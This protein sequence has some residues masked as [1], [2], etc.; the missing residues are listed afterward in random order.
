MD[1][2]GGRGGR[3]AARGGA[4]APACGGCF[5]AHAGTGVTGTGGTPGVSSRE[6]ILPEALR[7]TI[8]RAVGRLPPEPTRLV[9]VSGQV[10][11]EPLVAPFDLP[12]F[13]NAAMDGYAVRSED[14]RR[15]ERVSLRRVGTSLAGHPFAGSVTPGTAASIATGAML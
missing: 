8:V 6:L 4:C 7:D 12:R 5:R 2:A 9:D 3:Q 11:A 10:L 14:L 1:A 15:E 13:A